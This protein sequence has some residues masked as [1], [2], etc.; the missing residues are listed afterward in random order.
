MFT[1]K[2]KMR[3]LVLSALN[4]CAGKNCLFFKNK[5]CSHD[6]DTVKITTGECSCPKEKDS[7]LRLNFFE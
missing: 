3:R 7:I 6:K 5:I 2:E 1:K 4:G